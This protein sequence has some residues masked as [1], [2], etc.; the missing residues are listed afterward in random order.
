MESYGLEA[1]F[2][3]SQCLDQI[4]AP[5]SRTS[6]RHSPVSCRTR[7]WSHI[8]LAPEPINIERRIGPI[9]NRYTAS[10]PFMN[11]AD[12]G[13]VRT[14]SDFLR[15]VKSLL[16]G[17]I[18]RRISDYRMAQRRRKWAAKTRA[19]A[20]NEVYIHGVWDS[21]GGAAP[22]GEGSY[23]AWADHYVAT[24][25]K[26]IADLDV[27]SVLDIGTGD[28]NIGRQ[29]S[30]LVDEYLATDVSDFV[31]KRNQAMFSNMPSVKFM[32]LD[33]CVDEIPRVDLIL[34][35][36]VL[37]HISN[38]EVEQV[39]ANIERSGAGTA[40]IVEH[41]PAPDRLLSPNIDLG[42]HGPDLRTGMS[43]GLYLDQAPFSRPVEVIER[44]NYRDGEVL[45][46]YLLPIAR[47]N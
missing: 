2:A 35:R 13:K 39:L 11:W 31:I 27:K 9:D 38:A 45:T 7:S 22:S 29:I 46:Y 34:I 26:L 43:S 47:K 21:A 10:D 17:P 42:T 12:F 8:H 23:G 28:F 15:T 4:N 33:A 19:E 6:R 37:Q 5:R 24:V 14:L 20:F 1:F 32:T 18:Q 30:P 36:Q 40:L 25:S 16:P 3:D 44:C 41:H